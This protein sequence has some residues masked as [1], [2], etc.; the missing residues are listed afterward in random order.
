MQTADEAAS[1]RRR[2][3]S[4]GSGGRPAQAGPAS[5]NTDRRTRRTTMV[6]A[7]RTTDT[8]Q[9]GKASAADVPRIGDHAR[10]GV[11]RRP[12]VPLDVSGRSAPP[13]DAARL[14][15]AVRRDVA[16]P[17]RDLCGGR[18]RWCRAVGTARTGAGAGRGGGGVRSPPGGGGWR[19]RRA[20]LHNQ[21]ADRRAPPARR[22]LL[23]AVHG[24]RTPKPG[25]RDRLGSADPDARALRPRGSARLPRRHQP[26]QQA[27]LRAPRLP[28]GRRYAP[29]GGPPL[30]S[31]WREPGAGT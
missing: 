19:G 26:R 10:A 23:P 5:A 27:A 12:C 16:A 4:T 31:M 18:G 15:L 28:G 9:I 13:R 17:R 7:N 11:L 6:T 29:E 30:W 1:L 20:C 8:T 14:L 25:A 2:W 24:R 3:P 21:Q 22:L